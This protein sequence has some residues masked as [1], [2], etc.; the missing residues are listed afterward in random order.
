MAARPR[1]TSRQQAFAASAALYRGIAAAGGHEA[2]A[3]RLG[4]TGA[5]VRSWTFCPTARLETVSAVLGVPACELRPDLQHF[6]LPP[7]AEQATAAHLAAA[8]HFALTGRTLS[9]ERH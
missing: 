7:T 1:F 8:R 4:V 3:H 2:V 9:S 6:D 5:A